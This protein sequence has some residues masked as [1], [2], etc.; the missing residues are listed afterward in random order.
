ML[1]RLCGERRDT[2]LLSPIL[3]AHFYASHDRRH[4]SSK[5]L[6]A[7]IDKNFGTLPWCKRYLDRTGEKGYALAVSLPSVSFEISTRP[8]AALI[9]T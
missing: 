2:R 9:L 4:D 3:L 7:S 8:V 5:R 6:L 1:V